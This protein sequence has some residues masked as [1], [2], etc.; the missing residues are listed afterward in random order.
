MDGGVIEHDKLI[1]HKNSTIKQ[2][3][4][5]INLEFEKILMSLK[6]KS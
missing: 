6:M 3:E 2:F 4:S 5:V 1:I